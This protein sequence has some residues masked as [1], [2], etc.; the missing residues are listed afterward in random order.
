MLIDKVKIYVTGGRGG[1]GCQSMYKDLYNRRGVPDGGNGGD[2]GDIIIKA[3]PNLNTLLNLRFR[4]HFKADP[5]KHGGSNNKTGKRGRDSVILVPPGTVIADLTTG[6]VLKDLAAPGDKVIAA[7]GGR[8]GRGNAN[9]SQA[10][11]GAP[12]EHRTLGLELKLVADV[13]VVGLPNAGK[14]TLV[15]RI[16]KAKV[17]I[18]PYPFTTKSPVLGVVSCDDESFVIADMPGLIEGAHAGKGLGDRFLKHIERTSVLLHLVDIA[19]VDGSDPFDNYEL[20]EEEL[21]RYSD[22]LVS[23]PRVVAVNKTD[24]DE[25]GRNLAEFTERLGRDVLAV[26]ASRGDNLSELIGHIFE[27][28]KEHRGDHDKTSDR[29][30]RYSSPYRQEQQDR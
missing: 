6:E 2:G 9:I 18:A 12:G 16:S 1:S 19:P 20:L 3:D 13:G 28:V 10:E 8:G 23:K 27:K 11:K 26:S 15:S 25:D 4:Q 14:S 7:S 29:Q 21:A 24:I 30:D 17:K 22:R 5:G